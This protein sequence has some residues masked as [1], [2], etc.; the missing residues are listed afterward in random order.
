MF[1]VLPYQ[2]A[3]QL[4]YYQSPASQALTH[5][6]LSHWL[7]C[8]VIIQSDHQ[9]YVRVQGWPDKDQDR[10]NPRLF[11]LVMKRGTCISSMYSHDS[12]SSRQFMCCLEDWWTTTSIY[13]VQTKTGQ[14]SCCLQFET[15]VNG[16]SSWSNQLWRTWRNKHIMF[17]LRSRPIP[18]KQTKLSSNRNRTVWRYNSGSFRFTTYMKYRSKCPSLS[19]RKLSGYNLIILKVHREDG[20]CFS[21]VTQIDEP[22]PNLFLRF[23]SVQFPKGMPVNF[24]S[25]SLMFNLTFNWTECSLKLFINCTRLTRQLKNSRIQLTRATHWGFISNWKLS[26]RNWSGR[27]SV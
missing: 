26:K 10:W 4:H 7:L 15:E 12:P 27:K 14:D 23:L 21:S 22:V 19:F 13:S 24:V 16:P 8:K 2:L 6:A 1:T 9:E 20:K 25:F 5:Q 17:T 3:T 11:N 18:S